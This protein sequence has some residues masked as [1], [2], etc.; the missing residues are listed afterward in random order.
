MPYISYFDLL[1]TRG[2][3]DNPNIYYNN[4][5]VFFSTIQQMAIIIKGYG[6]VGVFS[7]CAYA[8]STDLS[9]LLNFLSLVQEKLMSQGLFMN[10][11]VRKGEIGMKSY[12]SSKDSNFCAINFD[13]SDIAN[14]YIS[15]TQFKGVGIFLDN[16]IYDD[17]PV[18]AESRI[19]TT[20][21]IFI[22]KHTD[23]QRE[24]FLPIVYR[25]I[26]LPSSRYGN[27]SIS[28]TM[29]II[30]K[31]LFSSYVKS[32]KFAAYYI[33][34][35]SNMIRSYCNDFKWDLAKQEFV[36]PSVVVKSILKMLTNYSEDINGL[37][38]IEYLALILLD[39]VYK[40][41]SLN[42]E[43]KRSITKKVVNIECVKKRFIH[44][45]SSIPQGVFS[46]I[47]KENLSIDHREMFIRFCQEDLSMNFVDKIME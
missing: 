29:E 20:N 42:E 39:E 11:V 1:G 23:A 8:E 35:L 37:P 41:Q 46:V 21:C 40:S 19:K 13:G 28:Q 31:A 16:S 7:D 38:G 22:S 18:N 45:L 24:V 17:I 12:H 25:D 5:K 15:Q 26:A 43:E 32:P 30:Y 47:N 3:C 44:Y 33:S 36:S 34:A 14:L 9:K 10:G 2:F 6:S 4:M 27:K